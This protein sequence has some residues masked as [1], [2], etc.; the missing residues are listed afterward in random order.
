MSVLFLS[1]N[2]SDTI[3]RGVRG[4]PGVGKTWVATSIAASVTTSQLPFGADR[5]GLGTVIHRANED[6][7]GILQYRFDLHGG[8]P[9]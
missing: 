5:R 7:P 6:P 8:D 4:D 9:D 2:K 1:R 3:A